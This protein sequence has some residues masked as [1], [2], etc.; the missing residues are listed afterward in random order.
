M[1]RLFLVLI[2]SGAVSGYLIKT[3]PKTALFFIFV[4]LLYAIGMDSGGR[5]RQHP[6]SNG[7]KSDR[8]YKSQEVLKK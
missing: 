1:W 7:I 2:V 6:R 3:Y 4:L 8:L 5:I